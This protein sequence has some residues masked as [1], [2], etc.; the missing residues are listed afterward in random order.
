MRSMVAYGSFLDATEELDPQT[1]KE[2]WVAIL[3][4]GID[5]EA[6][7][8]LSP[9]AK[10]FFL[11]AKPVIEKNFRRRKDGSEMPEEEAE[12][13]LSTIA[14]NCEH[15]SLEGE[16]DKEGD[17]EGDKEVEVEVEAEGESLRGGTTP[18]ADPPAAALILE[19]GSTWV[20]EPE[21]YAQIKTAYADIDVDAEFRKMAAACL[22]DPRKRRSKEHVSSF[23]LKWLRNAEKDQTDQPKETRPPNTKAR[24]GFDDFESRNYTNDEIDR[25]EM[26]ALKRTYGEAMKA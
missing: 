25:L 21:L 23:V 16:G 10:M 3:K 13:Q 6:P 5:R 22:A 1:F 15:P 4:Y 20:P 26:L 11:L 14:N 24:K 18:P 9:A 17:I 19:D 2:A 8:G 7:T 12:E